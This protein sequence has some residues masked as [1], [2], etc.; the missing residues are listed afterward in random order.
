[1]AVLEPLSANKSD[2]NSKQTIKE[3]MQQSKDYLKKK[4]RLARERNEFRL[5]GGY[6]LIYPI[7]SYYEE[8]KIRERIT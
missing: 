1:M 6:D 5:K 8:Y 4:K 3:Q 2:K 7:L